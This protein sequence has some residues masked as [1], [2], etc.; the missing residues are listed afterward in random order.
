M[1]RILVVD[2]NEDILLV[3]KLILEDFGYEVITL[4]DGNLIFDF[5]RKDR[6]D[7]ILLDV[8]LGNADGRELCREIKE[9]AEMQ[10]I[11]VILVSASHQLVECIGLNSGSPNDFLAKPF[12]IADLLQI[13]G[14]NITAA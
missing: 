2:D 9:C 14:I 5:I 4:A 7:L 11:P 10:D 8:M 6:P 3:M 12:D 1:S 13:V